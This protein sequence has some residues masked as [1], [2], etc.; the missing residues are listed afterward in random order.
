MSAAMSERARD[1]GREAAQAEHEVGAD[2][3][4]AAEQSELLAD[5]GEDEVGGHERDALLGSP[6]PTPAPAM[7]PAAE[8]E[9]RLHELVALAR[10]VGERVEPDADARAHVGEQEVRGRG[11]G[12]EQ[13]RR[14]TSTYAGRPVAT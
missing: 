11:A 3:R 5:G 1:G 7:P 14:P 9:E 4:R 10:R 12:D 6:R 13:Q 2:D 8:R